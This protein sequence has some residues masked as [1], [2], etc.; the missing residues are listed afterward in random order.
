MGG[1]AVGEVSSYDTGEGLPHPPGWVGG[2]VDELLSIY[3]KGRGERGGSSA[4]LYIGV[5]SGG[6]V[7]GE[8][9]R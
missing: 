6:W 8:R 2:W 7:G 9:I 3:Q 4:L 5:G 1:D